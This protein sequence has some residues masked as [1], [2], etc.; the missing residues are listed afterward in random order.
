MGGTYE[1][2]GNS[3]S[4]T[5]KFTGNGVF[6]STIAKSGSGEDIDYAQKLDGSENYPIVFDDGGLERTW[7]TAIKASNKAGFT[8]KGSGTLTLEKAPLY[9]GLTTVD[10]GKIIFTEAPDALIYNAFSAVPAANGIQGATVTKYA[11]P[12][13]T[14]LVYSGTETTFDSPLDVSN[15]TKI[16]LSGVTLVNGT[17]YTI[18][19]ATAITGYTKDAIEVVLP[20][21]ADATKWVLRRS[22]NALVLAPKGGFLLIIQ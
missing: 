5:V 12:A 20:E 18:V 9:T 15:V 13:N 17:T 14:T 11:Y 16:D 3:Q 19:S 1:V 21:G 22:G 10:G 6:R 8:K 7:A 2:T 4:G